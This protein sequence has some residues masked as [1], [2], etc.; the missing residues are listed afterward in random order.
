M[1]HLEKFLRTV[2]K[3][4]DSWEE[5]AS[6]QNFSVKVTVNSSYLRQANKSHDCHTSICTL[7][8]LFS[9]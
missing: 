5:K 2:Q 7:G 1:F 8:F 9:Q 4:A 3:Q 6:T